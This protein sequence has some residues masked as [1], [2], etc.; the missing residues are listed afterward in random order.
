MAADKV[1]DRVGDLPG[2][3]FQVNFKHYSGFLDAS[4][5]NHL[6]YWSEFHP[7]F[8]FLCFWSDFKN[9]FVHERLSYFHSREK[10]FTKESGSMVNRFDPITKSSYRPNPL[11][12]SS[13]YTYRPSYRWHQRW[14]LVMDRNSLIYNRLLTT[15]AGFLSLRASRKRRRSCFGWMEDRDARRSEVC[16]CHFKKNQLYCR[17]NTVKFMEE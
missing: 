17:A 12:A 8:Q 7:I 15:F 9:N 10:Y 6:H 11:Q 13:C 1:A 14:C 3:M 2:Q 5:G 4:E 16:P